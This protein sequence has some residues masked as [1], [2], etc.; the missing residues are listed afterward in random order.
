MTQVQMSEAKIERRKA[1]RA[2]RSTELIDAE[3]KIVGK[4]ARLLSGNAVNEAEKRLAEALNAVRIVG[5]YSPLL[6]EPDLRGI[7]CDWLDQGEGRTLA[8]PFIDAD[9][10]MS[11]REWDPEADGNICRD[12]KGIISSTGHAVEPAA[13]IIPCV[14]YSNACH[15]LGNGGGFFDRYIARVR[16][17]DGAA[18]FL[19]GVACDACTVSPSL[20]EPWDE[21]LD[22]I[23]TE[24]K[25]LFR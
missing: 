5:I 20:F 1:L 6:G 19:C 22:C 17:A 7:F 11:Y 14:G 12:A 16:Q 8:L 23:L 21:P 13:L 10:M 4:L 15:R 25:V 9:D 18:P 2:L 3:E 24:S